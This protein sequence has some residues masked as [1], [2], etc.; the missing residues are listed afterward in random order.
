[1]CL[2][3]IRE[4][5]CEGDTVRWQMMCALDGRDLPDALLLPAWLPKASASRCWQ[6]V[7]ASKLFLRKRAAVL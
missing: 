1:M 2:S 5:R 6:T 7:K 3:R 4:S